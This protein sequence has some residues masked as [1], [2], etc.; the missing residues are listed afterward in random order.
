VKRERRKEGKKEETQEVWQDGSTLAVRAHPHHHHD[1]P[2]NA[3]HIGVRVTT[4][5]DGS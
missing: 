5:V 1:C 2:D 3:G 4:T